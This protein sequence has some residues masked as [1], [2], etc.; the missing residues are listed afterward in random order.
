MITENRCHDVLPS[1]APVDGL[2]CALDRLTLSRQRDAGA[3]RFH[4]KYAGQDVAIEVETPAADRG[5][6]LGVS[7]RGGHRRRLLR[8][9]SAATH[10]FSENAIYIRDFADPYRAALSGAFDFMLVEFS[11]DWLARLGADVTRRPV[12]GLRNRTGCRDDTLGHLMR[13][14]LPAFALPDDSQALFLEQIGLAVG[15]HLVSQYAGS[16]V[17]TQP[18]RAVLSAP[19]VARAKELLSATGAGVG[20]SIESIAAECRLSPSYFIRAFRGSMGQ[21]P[22]QWQ[23]TQR[24]ARAQVW[25]AQG[26]MTLVDVASACGFSDQAHFTRVFSKVV[27]VSP[28][29]WRRRHGIMSESRR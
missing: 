1:A 27:G 10:D 15:C 5:F 24:I 20:V 12:G 9:R 21:T 26:A 2:G 14:M 8:G 29:Q 6:L 16:P 25:L 18:R 13:A 23:L 19:Q 7:L 3:L 11:H 22:Y 17:T 4:R 28:G